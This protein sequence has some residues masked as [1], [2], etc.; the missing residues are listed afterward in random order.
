M[1]IVKQAWKHQTISNF[2]G[3]IFNP[4]EMDQLSAHQK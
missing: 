1:N 3:I 2:F 4:V